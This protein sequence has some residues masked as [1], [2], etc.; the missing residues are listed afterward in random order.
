M[1]T[2][3]GGNE[4]RKPVSLVFCDVV[5]S[6]ALAD[7][8]DEELVREVMLRYYAAMRE[9]IAAHGGTVSKFIGDAV[10]AAFGIPATR[11]DDALRAVRAAL[12]MGAS[13][14]EL[15]VALERDCGVRLST[16]TGV[17]TGTV[18]AA[19]ALDDESVVLGDPAN[20]AARLEQAAAA[21]EI[22]VG[23][24]TWQLTRHAARYEEVAP[25]DAKGKPQ[26]LRAFPPYRPAGE[27][28]RE[29]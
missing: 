12:A 9:A 17:Y 29:A 11:E 8:H 19:G 15:N 21:D 23:E 24:T 16:R 6:T 13:L 1:T 2:P 27:S 26:P 20:T 22:L 3:D 14:A 28:S 18:L 5:G 4:R 7:R 25:V 10:V